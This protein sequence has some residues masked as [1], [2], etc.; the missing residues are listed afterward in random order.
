MDVKAIRI[1]NPTILALVEEHAKP[2]EKT[3]TG[4]AERLIIRGAI[5]EYRRI[6]DDMGDQLL[7]LRQKMDS[8]AARSPAHTS[9]SHPS[10]IPAS[11]DTVAT[12]SARSAQRHAAVA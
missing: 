5:A 9:A 7:E 3:A 8:A 10:P 11:A 6:S 2:H 4:V 12:D 1:T